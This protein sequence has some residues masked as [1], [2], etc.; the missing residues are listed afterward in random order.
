[1]YNTNIVGKR[2]TR[3]SR[4]AEGQAYLSRRR[5]KKDSKIDKAL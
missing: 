3:Q 2:V 5:A 4:E 1:M